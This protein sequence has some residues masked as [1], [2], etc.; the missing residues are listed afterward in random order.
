MSVVGE[1]PSPSRLPSHKFK[2]YNVDANIQ[3]TMYDIPTELT[4]TQLEAK[5]ILKHLLQK[6]QNSDSRHAARYSAW[7]AR[8]P[9]LPDLCLRCVRP[10]VWTFLSGRWSLDALKAVGG[11]LKHSGAGIYLDGVLGLDRR[12]RMYI[13]QAGS[14]RARVA[15]HLN[16]RY[17]RDNPSLH[18]HAMQKSIYNAIGVVAQIPSQGMGNHALP[19][20]D[21]QDLL[22]NVLEM[23]ICLVFRSLPLQTLEEWLPNDGSV[24]EGRKSGLEGEFCGLN[25]ALP[26]DQGEKQREWVDLSNDED[27]LVREYANLGRSPELKSEEKDQLKR[28]VEYVERAKSYNRHWAQVDTY[29]SQT[30]G[31]VLAFTMAVLVGTALWRG[32]APGRWR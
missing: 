13:G 1:P 19:G 18:Y 8:H 15:Q 7:I 2:P 31:I 16:F 4:P 23:W 14:I 27:P 17:R 12:V 22:L 25:I 28:R 24:K 20:M 29:P 5:H 10:Q 11:D 32:G 6:L 26:L 9:H 21:C 3:S 30:T